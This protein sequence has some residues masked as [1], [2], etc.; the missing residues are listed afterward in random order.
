[1]AQSMGEGHAWC[2]QKLMQGVPA[3]AGAGDLQ[4]IEISPPGLAGTLVAMVAASD[5]LDGI[6]LFDGWHYARLGAQWV[7]VRIPVDQTSNEPLVVS[8]S[9]AGSVYLTDLFM[10]PGDGAVPLPLLLTDPLVDFSLS[11]V[12][13]Q[14]LRASAS[15]ALPL[16]GEGGYLM[17]L[18][19][20][21]R[22]NIGQVELTV[23]AR[24]RDYA[25][26]EATIREGWRW[27]IIPLPEGGEEAV[28]M[29]WHDLEVRPAWNPG[30]SNFPEDLGIRVAVMVAF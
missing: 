25:A 13:S 19:T 21:G 27:S 3:R 16:A 30:L 7:M 20:H 29:I 18:A 5:G 10:L 23:S 12:H 28:G 11:S 15:V 6:I 1:M 4:E 14:W 17:M 24:E 26:A 8:L 9:S 2:I 22:D